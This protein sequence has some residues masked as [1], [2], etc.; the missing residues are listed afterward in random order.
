MAL[1]GGWG[2]TWNGQGSPFV[3]GGVTTVQLTFTVQFL[4]IFV[5]GSPGL[6]V[7]GFSRYWLQSL[8]SLTLLTLLTSCA[9]GSCLLRPGLFAYTQPLLPPLLR[10]AVAVPSVGLS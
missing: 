10:E 2:G 6:P 4:N 5:R 7:L 9:R 1:V 8:E 3:V